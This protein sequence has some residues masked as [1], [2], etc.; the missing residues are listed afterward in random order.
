MTVLVLKIKTV[1]SRHIFSMI[2]GVFTIIILTV[3]VHVQSLAQQKKAVDFLA[4]ANAV[5]FENPDSAYF[6]ATNAKDAALAAK[7]DTLIAGAEQVLGVVEG[8]RGNY[9]T[10]LQHFLPALVVFEKYGM[11]KRQAMLLSNIARVIL[12]QQ[13]YR[14][15]IGYLQRARLLDQQDHN[16]YGVAS[17][18]MNLGIIYRQLG[19][20]DSALYYYKQAEGQAAALQDSHAGILRG[21]LNYNLS[22]VYTMLGDYKNAAPKLQEAREYFDSV[23]HQPSIVYGKW[24]QSFFDLKTE[25]YQKAIDQALVALPE[26]RSLQA[27]EVTQNL[28]MVLTEA[29][30][31]LHNYEKSLAYHQQYKTYS[32]SVYNSQKART[33]AELQYAYETEKKDKEIQLLRQEEERQNLMLIIVSVGALAAIFLSVVIILS[34]KVQSLRH[35]ERES[36]LVA[37][38]N[39]VEHEKYQVESEKRIEEERNKQLQLE[40]EVNQRELAMNTL[41]IHQKNKLLDDLHQEMD[42]LGGEMDGAQKQ[43]VHNIGKS[44]KQ[45]INFENDWDNIKMHFERVHPHF[46]DKLKSICGDL[47]MNELKQIAYIRINLT[48]KEVANLLNIDHASVKMSRYRIKKKLKLGADDSLRDFIMGV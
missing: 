15:A 2:K 26:S 37:E 29:Y 8:M 33:V 1:F 38:R 46:F 27:D 12:A 43:L 25:S 32:D 16:D 40:L 13:R 7:N 45:H 3:T 35:R 28:L 6:F 22:Y 18:L 44:L 36:Q 20:L 4:N 14:E 19:I 9:S 41:F 5:L 23:K 17:G 24:L 39:Q 11:T 31:K 42:K 48:S 21:N 10:S 30:Q 34:K 47:T